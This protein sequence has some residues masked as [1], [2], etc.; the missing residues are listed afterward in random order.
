MSEWRDE[1]LL[2][3]HRCDECEA[4]KTPRRALNKSSIVCLFLR[5]KFTLPH[6]TD[7]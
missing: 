2:S 7:S 1:I 5:T 6:Q 4:K 3:K